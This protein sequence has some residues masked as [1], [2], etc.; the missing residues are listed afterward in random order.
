MVTAPK[1]DPRTAVVL[2]NQVRT[3]LRRYVPDIRT[4]DEAGQLNEALINIFA[5]YGEVLISRLNRVP[6][7]YLFAFLDLIGVSPEPP[8]AARV[9]LTFYLTADTINFAVVPAHTQVA[10]ELAKGEQK[11]VIYETERELI[12]APVRLESLYL[13]DAA[14]DQYV[15]WDSALGPLAPPA[16]QNVA[17]PP[18]VGEVKLI[19]HVFYIGLKP[20]RPWPA[21][22]QLRF[23]FVLDEQTALD[24]RTV[25]WE[26]SGDSKAAAKPDAPKTTGERLAPPDALASINAVSPFVDGT[27]N[28]TKTGDVVFFNIGCPPVTLLEG[29]VAHWFACRLMTPIA[30][31]PD[32]SAGM[33]RESHLP[34]IRSLST[35]ISFE[36]KGLLVQQAFAN[37]SKADVSKD[38]F[39]FGEKPKFGDTFYLCSE[40]FSDPDAVVTLHVTLTNPTSAGVNSPIT[41]VDAHDTKLTWEYWDGQVWSALG[42]SE[43]GGT[44]AARRVRIVRES[45]AG[46]VD[47]QFS[48]TTQALSE[49]GDIRFRFDKAPAALA[50][51]G[52]NGYWVRVRITAGDYGRDTQYERDT[53]SG[54]YVVAPASFAPP[55]IHAIQ[56]DCSVKKESAPEAVFAYNDFLFTRI[57]PDAEPFHPFRPSSSG[58]TMPTLYMGFTLPSVSRPGSPRAVVG[59]ASAAGR[60]PNR[61]LSIYVALGMSSMRQPQ[62]L[63]TGGSEVAC[64]EYWNGSVWHPWTVRDETQGLRRSGLIR[65]LAPADARTRSD[66]G[67][68][69]YWL[70][71]RQSDPAFDPSIR[72]MLLNTTMAQEGATIVAEVLGTS[73]GRP[74]QRFRTTQSPVLD[75]QQLEIREP[76]V[77]PSQEQAVI[78]AEEGNDAIG[79][80]ER[81]AGREEVWVRWHE[82]CNFYG[83]KP[84]DRHYVIDHLRGEVLFGDGE[85]GQIPPPLA[86][87]IRLRSYRT[88]GG[89][90][91][92]KPA[93]AAKQLKSAV[94]YI[95]KVVNWEAADGGADAE[96]APAILQR[97]PRSLRHGHRAVTREDFE[98]LARLASSEIARAR[99]VPLFD[100]ASD[101]DA[102]QRQPGTV[103]VIVVPHSTDAQPTP[104]TEVCDRVREYL[105]Q[106]SPPALNLVLVG[107]EYVELD[108]EAT[109]AVN[110]V[111]QAN[112]VELAA[113]LALQ[114]YLHP[115]TGGPA[116]TGWSFGRMPQKSDLY[117]VLE[118]IAGL[119]HVRQL[120]LTCRPCRPG[121]E[122]TGRFLICRGKQ[123]LNIVPED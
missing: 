70:R 120:Q 77:P 106:Y 76:G 99:C 12:V 44:G 103:S 108:V 43:I 72:R 58:E 29:V 64:W 115:V 21:V 57:S 47:T 8:Q 82:V 89:V 53:E 2:A 92:N 113:T 46:P 34:Q 20:G 75:G 116:G 88:G 25:Q 24:D 98:D 63:S 11:P 81:S 60:F 30:R 68:E 79:A 26:V 4:H 121:A 5:R 36:R 51:N 95:D 17:Q 27:A 19:P 1:I 48:D 50:I 28:L 61:S 117:A 56:I 110:D 33:V 102:R 49:S 52:Q 87:N 66:F 93:L 118:G 100:L 80:M 6:D 39:P 73:N 105:E 122:T 38:F 54:A 7:K 59:E 104:S 69:R 67:V 74:A 40:A 111:D 65:V 86:N 45:E 101:P 13:K 16:A 10:A 91:G 41:P 37:N 119:S 55:S 96:S 85:N 78:K 112:E 23:R 9:P 114:R 42:T 31:R 97:G 84:R 18:A 3:L 83:S 71:M 22:N 90:A 32:V 123:R 107:P 109:L 62:L 94:P 14:R 15:K 35:E